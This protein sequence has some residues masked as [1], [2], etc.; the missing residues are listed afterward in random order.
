MELDATT[1]LTLQAL[2]ESMWRSETRFDHRY[3]DAVLHP[4]F[5]EIGRSGRVFSRDDVL[6]MPWVE[7]SVDIPLSNLVFSRLADG[8]ILLTYTTVPTHSEHGAAHRASVWVFE[9]KRWLL[10]YH[11]GTPTSL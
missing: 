1:R 7:I 10:R 8:V 3:M 2:E 6:E 5:T 9:A 11:Q 4:D